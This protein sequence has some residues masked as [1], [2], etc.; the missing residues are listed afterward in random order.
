MLKK[1]PCMH[2]HLL[3]SSNA[4]CQ[5][6]NDPHKFHPLSHSSI[7]HLKRKGIIQTLHKNNF[8]IKFHTN[9][10]NSGHRSCG[11]A[12]Q[13][14]ANPATARIPCGINPSPR[15]IVLLVG[16]QFM[17]HPIA[18][19]IPRPVD[20]VKIAVFA[21]KISIKSNMQKIITIW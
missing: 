7:Q 2:C 18:G 12:H 15:P 11:Q 21:N 8:I 16:D 5:A 1:L 3:T 14:N 6:K 4:P 13:Q 19:Q 20:G 10:N 9:I 17:A